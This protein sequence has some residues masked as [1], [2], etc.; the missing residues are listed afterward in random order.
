MHEERICWT[1]NELIFWRLAFA[2]GS[3]EEFLFSIPREPRKFDGPF[4]TSKDIRL[5]KK[6]K[7]KKGNKGQGVDISEWEQQCTRTWLLFRRLMPH[8]QSVWLTY[9]LL[10]QS[11][12]TVSCFTEGSPMKTM[13]IS[14]RACDP[15]STVSLYHGASAV[16]NVK[17]YHLHWPVQ[18]PGW[19]THWPSSS[20]FLPSQNYINFY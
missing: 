18:H 2:I 3:L 17:V 4:G 6:K 5:T 10:Y 16:F 14:P 12:A 8:E 15:V 1:G 11:N 7:K 19:A 20:L 9:M 13:H